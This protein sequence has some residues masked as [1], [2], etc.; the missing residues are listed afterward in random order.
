MHTCIPPPPHRRCLSTPNP[1]H[2][3]ASG[4]YPVPASFGCYLI[5]IMRTPHY[6]SVA[7]VYFGRHIWNGWH[8]YNNFSDNAERHVLWIHWIY[9]IDWWDICWNCCIITQKRCVNS[10]AE[11]ISYIIRMDYEDYDMRIE[12]ASF[13]YTV[14][15]VFAWYWFIELL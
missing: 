9:I 4:I 3:F 12:M 14:R 10:V 11:M 1:S 2:D 6:A 13:C 5:W 8:R 7:Y 15:H